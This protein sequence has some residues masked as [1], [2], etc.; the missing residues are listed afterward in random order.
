M[1]GLPFYGQTYK[2][3]DSTKPEFGVAVTGPGTAGTYTKN[4]GTLAYYEVVNIS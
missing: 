3:K 1:L 4:E 2:L